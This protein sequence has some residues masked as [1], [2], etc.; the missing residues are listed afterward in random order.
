MGIDMGAKGIAGEDSE[1]NEEHIILLIGNWRKGNACYTAAK[2][3]V[4]LYLHL[5]ENQTF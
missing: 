2:S 4:E 1:G 5:C 3:L